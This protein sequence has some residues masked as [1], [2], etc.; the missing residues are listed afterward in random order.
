MPG[1]GPRSYGHTG[2]GARLGI[3]DPDNGVAF[4]YLCSRMRDIGPEGDPRWR[5]LLD[6]V[7]GCVR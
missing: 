2:A 7:A 1:L 4:G 6:A 5:R 3:A